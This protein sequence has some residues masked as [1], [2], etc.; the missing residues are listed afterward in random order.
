LGVRLPALGLLG[1]SNQAQNPQR[2]LT[3]P[4]IFSGTLTIIG[5]SVPLEKRALYLS[6]IA[7]MNGIASVVGPILGGVFT[8][9][10]SWRWYV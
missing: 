10:L 9:R 3:D 5:Y 1:M 6:L 7:S 4:S 8:D 2:I